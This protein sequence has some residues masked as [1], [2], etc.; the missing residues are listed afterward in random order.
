MSNTQNVTP[1]P[2][3]RRVGRV[4]EATTPG[5]EGFGSSLSLVIGKSILKIEYV[6][7][8]VDTIIT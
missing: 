2:L 7:G 5:V 6:D 3:E 8:V 1:C 4:D